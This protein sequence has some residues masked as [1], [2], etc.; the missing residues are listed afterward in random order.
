MAPRVI[1]LDRLRTSGDTSLFQGGAHDVELTFFDA[2]PAAGKG[3]NLHVHPYPE[4]FLVQ[5]GEAT[6]TVDGE[7]I[8][9]RG[10]NVVIVP[11]E[12][13]HKFVN[14]GEER[15]RI[16]TLHPSGRLIQT[17]LE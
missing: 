1:P 16:V 2:A 8:A 10:G 14:S 13:P 5:E 6:F 7:E 9:V 3:P 4:V 17:D 15:L 11:P 12:T